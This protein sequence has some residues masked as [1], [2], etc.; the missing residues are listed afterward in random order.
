MIEIYWMEDMMAESIESRSGHRSQP[1]NVTPCCRLCQV[2]MRSS[3]F[4][5]KASL[6]PDDQ[7]K[8]FPP[9]RDHP[10]MIKGHPL[11]PSPRPSQKYLQYTL[12]ITPPSLAQTTLSLKP[13]HLP[14]SLTSGPLSALCSFDPSPSL[15]ELLISG[16]LGYERTAG[17]GG[18]YDVAMGAGFE[19]I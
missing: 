12:N 2:L 8:Y 9:T 4:C 3:A 6:P 7:S 14:L 10:S 19:M 17:T 5:K 1:L 13:M 11:H 18:R 15:L 16:F